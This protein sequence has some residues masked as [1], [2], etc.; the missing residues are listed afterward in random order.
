MLIT[1]ENPTPVRKTYQHWWLLRIEGNTT[2][3][4]TPEQSF[5]IAFVFIRGNK[6]ANGTWELSNYSDDVRTLQVADVFKL[7]TE[8]ALKGNMDVAN[9]LENLLTL[10]STLAK[11]AGTID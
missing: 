11:T 5:A 2:Q 3:A 1:S 9:T 6:L 7:A 8:E 10:S 4:N